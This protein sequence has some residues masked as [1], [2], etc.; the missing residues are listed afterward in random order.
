MTERTKPLTEGQGAQL[1]S[2]EKGQQATLTTAPTRAQGDRPTLPPGF[3]PLPP[4]LSPLAPA[5]IP[6]PRGE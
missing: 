6:P 2:V 4:P 3:V 5:Q 1:L